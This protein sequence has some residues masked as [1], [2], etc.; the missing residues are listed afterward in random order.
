MTSL[1]NDRTAADAVKAALTRLG[2]V[3]LCE[4]LNLSAG[5]LRTDGGRGLLIRCP[6]HSERTPSCHIDARS[7]TILARCHGSCGEGGDTLALVAAVYGLDVE[8]DF[9]EVL[10]RGAELGGVDL[11]G[12]ERDVWKPAPT[13]PAPLPKSYPPSGEVLDL[14]LA[15]RPCSADAEATAWLASRSIDAAGIDRYHCARAI[16]SGL[17][18]PRWARYDGRSWYD[19]GYRLVVPMFDAEGALASVRARAIATADGAPSAKGLPAS[20]YAAKGLVMACP[21]ATLMLGCGAWPA[22]VERR[23]VICEGEPDWLSWCDRGEGPRTTA[24]LGI[25]GS[26]QWTPEIA[27][28]IPDGS[29]VIVR[30][31]RDDAGD[32]YAED[33][34]AT[35]RGRC[36]VLEADAD[37]RAERR[38]TR[39]QRE[40]EARKRAKPFKQRDLQF[41][42]G[43]R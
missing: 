20:G 15:C 41:G 3:R 19:L 42:V 17:T 27:D 40:E 5:A 16:H 8:R 35:L 1:S 2:V 23:V 36:M 39:A 24:V 33:I 37:G 31:D 13:P 38:R 14:W 30:T 6:W 29:K 9:R 26:G 34:V 4:A 10:A 18:L 32:R 21:L 43:W 25:G 28:R 11:E 7:G 22:G 12:I